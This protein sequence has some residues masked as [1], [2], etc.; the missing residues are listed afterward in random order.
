MYLI[1]IVPLLVAAWKQGDYM[2]STKSSTVEWLLLEE[3]GKYFNLVDTCV[4][5]NGLKEITMFLHNFFE[6]Y[7][8]GICDMNG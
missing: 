3:I 8:V 5:I 7:T 6:Q 4:F 1:D 2:Y